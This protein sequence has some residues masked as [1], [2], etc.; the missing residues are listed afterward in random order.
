MSQ[1]AASDNLS[2]G[3]ASWSDSQIIPF[4]GGA[5]GAVVLLVLYVGLITLAESFRHALNQLQT[6][7]VWV[8]LVALGLGVQVGLYIRVRQIVR[9]GTAAG[10]ALTGTGT[11]TSTV[12]MIA[13]CAHHLTDLAPIIGLT[14]ATAFLSRYR[15]AFI[16][17][18]LVVNLVGILLSLRTLRQVMA[19][20]RAMLEEKACH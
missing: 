13:C 18:G 1:R 15:L 7:A 8:T 19:H 16:L 2:Q 11:G 9:R 17:A 20:R 14:S 10:N 3:P 12:G 6:D 5:A 4:L